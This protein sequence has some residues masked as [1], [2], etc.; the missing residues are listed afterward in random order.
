MSSIEMKG[1]DELLLKTDK[2]LEKLPKE[3][4]IFHEKAGDLILTNVKDNTPYDEDRTEGSHLKEA[5]YVKIGSKGGYAAVKADY[6]GRVT[7]HRAPHA[8]LVEE[9]HVVKTKDG[10]KFVRGKHMFEKGMN[11]S[12]GDLMMMAEYFVDMIGGELE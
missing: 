11:E 5:M 3:R 2:L 9:G 8:H 1:F 4:R 10:V 7:G 6:S 12:K